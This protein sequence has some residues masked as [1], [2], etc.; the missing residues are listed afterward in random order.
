MK[1]AICY[2]GVFNINYIRQKGVDEH[3]LKIVDETINNHKD[4]LYSDLLNDKN[5]VDTFL[6]SYNID[7][8]LNELLVTGYNAKNFVFLD[9]NQIN[10]NTWIA[11]LNHLK[12][13]ISMIREEETR[14]KNIYDYFIF[15]RF[16]VDFHKN[17]N[18]FKLELDK[19]NITVEHPSGNCD[20]NLW[21]FP[22]NYLDIF[23]NSV[24]ALISEG[25]MTHELNHKIT[26]FGG[27]IS[28]IDELVESYMGHTIFSF[29][30]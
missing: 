4:K 19:L 6:S 14:T 5:E 20:D 21:I 9:K 23:E 8:K 28:Y 3:L 18:T 13:L 22:R 1:F 2:K 11:Q 10:T 15:T 17:Y 25:K 26:F 27:N 29:I 24:D 7:K 12:I 30:R 16:D